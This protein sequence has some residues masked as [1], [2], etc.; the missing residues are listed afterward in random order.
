MYCV[1]ERCCSYSCACTSHPVHDATYTTN[2][3]STRCTNAGTPSRTAAFST[4]QRTPRLRRAPAFQS[5]TSTP[6][7][8][9]RVER[10]PLGAGGQAEPHP[11]QRQPRPEPHPRPPGA[12]LAGGHPGPG[13]VPVGDQARRR[14]GQEERQ[15]DVEQRQPGQHQVHAVE[16]EQDARDAAEQRR[17]GEAAYQPDQHQ[18]HQRPGDGSGDPPAERVHPECLLA[19]RDQPLADLGVHHHRRVV[20]PDPGRGAAVEDPLVGLVDVARGRSR[21]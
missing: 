10:R 14:A 11:G 9:Q 5:H 1:D 12:A 2:A 7:R 15:E 18:H 21:G 17:A 16:A 3:T 4:G 6:E 20:L 8:G 19:Q 13:P